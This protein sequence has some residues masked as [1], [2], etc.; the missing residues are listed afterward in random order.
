ME[1]LDIRA[2]SSEHE[3]QRL[4]SE[5]KRINAAGHQSEPTTPPEYRDNGFPTAISRPNR[6]SLASLSALTSS[7]P[8]A[9]NFIPSHRNTLS[10]SHHG[11]TPFVSQPSRTPSDS[12]STSQRNSDED[13]NDE[14]PEASTSKRPRHSAV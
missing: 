4:E 6:L 10:A 8:Q 7:P 11:V 5:V 12:L 13:E 1:L 14:V 9:N 3:M 2:K